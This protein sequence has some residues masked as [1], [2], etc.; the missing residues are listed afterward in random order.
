[1]L[2]FQREVFTSRMCAMKETKKREMKAPNSSFFLFRNTHTR[3][4]AVEKSLK[5]QDMHH[6]RNT[7]RILQRII[8]LLLFPQRANFT[9][10]LT[11]IDLPH[12]TFSLP[13]LHSFA[14]LFFLTIIQ[15]YTLI[16]G[17]ALFLRWS[18]SVCIFRSLFHFVRFIFCHLLF[19]VD[20]QIS[21]AYNTY[22]L[23]HNFQ[24]L[25]VWFLIS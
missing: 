3:I 1:M 7:P 2:T 16:L 12:S 21:H 5:S 15:T 22:S 11:F 17:F 4:I 25:S 18:V 24:C 13:V 20:Q 9:I 19:L 23:R 6:A 8:A 14:L 10:L